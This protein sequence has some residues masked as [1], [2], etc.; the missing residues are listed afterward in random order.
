MVNVP[1]HLDVGL[2]GLLVTLLIQQHL[3]VR[4][5]PRLHQALHAVHVIHATMQLLGG[6]EVIDAN[7]QAPSLALP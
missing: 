7:E 4:E 1:P 6:A 2:R 3:A 5:A